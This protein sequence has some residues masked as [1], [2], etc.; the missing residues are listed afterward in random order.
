MRPIFDDLR[1]KVDTVVEDLPQGS[2]TP[3]VNDEFGDVFGSVYALY[4]DG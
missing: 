4:G 1:R 3:V 2:R